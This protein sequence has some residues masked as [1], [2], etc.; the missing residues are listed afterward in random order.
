MT[1]TDWI[2]FGV[3]LGGMV[4]YAVWSWRTPR[5]QAQALQAA[6][7]AAKLE[8]ETLDESYERFKARERVQAE[9]AAAGVPT[10]DESAHAALESSMKTLN[11]A[12]PA[13]EA[14]I[15][16]AKGWQEKFEKTFKVIEQ[17]ERERDVWKQMYYDAGLG[18]M[19][20]QEMLF[21]E[22]E[23]LS[24]GAKIPVRAHLADLVS[25][26]RAKHV[27]SPESA[28]AKVASASAPDAISS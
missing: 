7:A 22:I 12:L 19:N 3:V 21:R 20:A 13:L 17:M 28:E 16:E 18:H 14:A 23:R 2:L 1:V 4:V 24:V 25:G 9:S 5:A 6:T 27:L 10:P 11:L 8:R 15:L 26:Y